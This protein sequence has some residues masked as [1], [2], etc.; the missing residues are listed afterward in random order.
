MPRAIDDGIPRYQGPEAEAWAW[1]IAS[2]ETARSKRIPEAE[3]RELHFTDAGQRSRC[4]GIEFIKGQR[5]EPG[6]RFV[7]DTRDGAQGYVSAAAFARTFTRI[8]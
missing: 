8:R 1:Q 4:V 6:G 7:V 2:V 5:P 3:G